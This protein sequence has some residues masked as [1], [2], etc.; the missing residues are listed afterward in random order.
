MT[1][2]QLPAKYWFF[3]VKRACEVLNMMPIKRFDQI[4]TPFE[5]VY[6]KKVDYRTLFPMFSTAYIKQERESG[7]GSKWKGRSLKCICVGTCPTSD[8]LLFYHPPSKQTLSCADRYRFNSF[9]PSGPQFSEKYESNFIFN[10]KSA[11]DNIH[12]PLTHESNCTKY[13][14]VPDTDEYIEVTILSVPVNDDT[15]P[16]VIQHKHSGDIME[17]LASELTDCNPNEHPTDIPNSLHPL[18]HM[19]WIHNDAKVTLYL[20][21]IMTKPKH[22]FLSLNDS[23]WTFMPGRKK[24]QSPID[25]PNFVE[26]AESMVHN[27]K[28]FQGWKSQ[29]VTLTARRVRITSNILAHRI[30]NRKVSAAN[31]NLLEAPTLLKHDKLHPDD[32]TT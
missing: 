31:L 1:S 28:L 9:S 30:I 24:T 23:S 7:P 19:P 3:G 27:K 32:K 21:H 20:P 12:Q 25:L 4:T 18:R 11:M 29:A 17:A 14:R 8:S 5:V 6:K 2:S 22:G 10:T 13:Y 15:D 26:L 16:Y